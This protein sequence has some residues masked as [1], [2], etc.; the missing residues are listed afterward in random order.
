MV[1][2]YSDDNLMHEQYYFVYHVSIL[3]ERVHITIS[4]IRIPFTE[5]FQ[6]S[7]Q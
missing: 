3:G 4:I 7:H 5:P 6:H 1:W 2:W